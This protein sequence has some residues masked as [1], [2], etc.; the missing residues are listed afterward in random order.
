MLQLQ[1]HPPA[2]LSPG[3]DASEKLTF[4]ATVKM[5]KRGLL[6]TRP[7]RR[8]VRAT[9]VRCRP[10]HRTSGGHEGDPPGWRTLQARQHAAKLA[11]CPP[12]KPPATAKP[13]AVAA[14]GEPQGESHPRGRSERPHLPAGRALGR[15]GPHSATVVGP[16]RFRLHK[17]ASPKSAGFRVSGRL[18]C[19]AAS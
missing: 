7:I 3:R 5:G 13:A 12:P 11:P 16:G 1:P 9:Q 15:G 17:R 10:P 2:P 14:K 6:R 18:G 19:G 4:A 8:P